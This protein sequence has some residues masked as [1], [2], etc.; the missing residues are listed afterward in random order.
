MKNLLLL[1]LCV[2]AWPA[3][4]SA[5]AIQMLGVFE[6]RCGSCHTKPAA[7]RRVPDRDSL[8]Q[9]TPE[10]VYDALTTGSMKVN[11]E[12]LT[13]A[14]KKMIAEFITERPLGAALAGQASAMPNRCA[15]TPM[16]ALLAGPAW[17]GWGVD[18]G[19]PRF[20]P[21]AAAG[22]TADQVPKLKLKWAFGFPNGTSAYGQPAI[23]GG[24]LFIGSDNGFVY[25]LDAATG[26]VYWSFQ[27]SG[28][29]RTAI[30][31]GSV[32]SGGSVGWVGSVGS[33][34]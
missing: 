30:S 5:Q 27:S 32:G 22:L 28:G 19:N 16:G 7:D 10:A 34:G 20:Q 4:A 14:Q 23:A 31:L 2:S 17:N 9:R 33:V 6:Q 29:V 11:A 15:N 13:D 21:A 1:S 12:G 26:C 3:S 24:R 18:G 25:S 8:R